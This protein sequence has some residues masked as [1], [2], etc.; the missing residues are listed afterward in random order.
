MPCRR[1]ELQIVEHGPTQ[2]IGQKDVECDR[3]GL[4]LPR[5]AQRQLPTIGDDAF[6]TL[7]P[8]HSQQN[9]RVVRIVVHDEQHAVTFMDVIP[10]VGNDFLRLRNDR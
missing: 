3:G 4:V 6:E 2:H 7:L 1:I 8:R 9:S 10:I 5:Q